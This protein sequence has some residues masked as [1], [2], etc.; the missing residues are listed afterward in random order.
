MPRIPVGKPEYSTR[1]SKLLARLNLKQA[2]ASLRLN[3]DQGAISNWVRGK[4][5]PSP[6]NFVSLAGLAE[7]VEKAWFLQQA[8]ITDAVLKASAEVETSR[9]LISIADSV[10]I[11]VFRSAGAGSFRSVDET[12]D[13]TVALPRAW[14]CM[15]TNGAEAGGPGRRGRFNVSPHRVQ[16]L[17]S[18][19]TAQRKPRPR[20]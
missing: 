8:G 9:E 17:S 14:L 15:V 2:P 13:H 12:P 16:G 11:K 18:S 10:E 3:V 6:E 19:S 5:R 20:L 7:G 1:I 4:N